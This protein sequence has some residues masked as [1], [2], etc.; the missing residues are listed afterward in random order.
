MSK[1]DMPFDRFKQAVVFQY[2]LFQLCKVINTEL[3]SLLAAFRNFQICSGLSA[4]A[5]R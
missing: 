5:A 3:T 1:Q 2:L 4:V